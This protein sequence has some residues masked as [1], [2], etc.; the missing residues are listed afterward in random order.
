MLIQTSE[1]VDAK[2]RSLELGLEVPTELALLPRH[3][4]TAEARSDL[5]YE[6]SVADIRALWRAEHLV[7]TRIDGEWAPIPYIQEKKYEWM[8]PPILVGAA[9]WSKDPYVIN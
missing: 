5:V 6:S 8:F 4:D 1:Y 2:Q 3:F 9:I 7:E